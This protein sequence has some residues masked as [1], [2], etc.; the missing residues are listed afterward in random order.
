MSARRR[1]RTPP[2]LG[3]APWA[4]GRRTRATIEDV[5]TPPEPSPPT[6]AT[7]GG[8]ATDWLDREAAARWFAA[9]GVTSLTARQLAKLAS[10]GRG[11]AYHK[12][13]KYAYYRAE[14]LN[15]WLAAEM[16][17][18]TNGRAAPRVVGQRRGVAADPSPPPPPRPAA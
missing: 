6:A 17:P 5:R 11:P 15:A 18:V 3:E 14:D 10:A 13:G 2:D 12:L 16:R 1:P 8:P 7:S 4:A 9:R